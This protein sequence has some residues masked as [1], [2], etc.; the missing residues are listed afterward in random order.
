MGDSISFLAYSDIHHHEYKDGISGEDV[1][2][3]EEEA[4]QLIKEHQVDFW[5]FLGDR[6]VSRNPL[7]ISRQRADRA[8]KKKADLGIPGIL[9]PGNHD[10]RTKNPYSGHSMEH[11]DIYRSD[12]NNIVVFNEAHS[13]VV[14]SKNGTRVAVHGTPAGHIIPSAPLILAAEWNICIFHGMIIGSLFENGTPATEGIDP[15]VL[16]RS[17]YDLVLGG[18]NHKHQILPLR[19]TK[20]YYVGAPMQHNWGDVNSPRGFCL[21]TLTTTPTKQVQV[22]HILSHAPQFL[23]HQVRINEIEDLIQLVM[24]KRTEW[25]DNLIQL[26]LVGTSKSLDGI[27]PHEWETKI[28]EETKAR[29]VRIRLDFDIQLVAPTLQTGRRTEADEWQDYL[30]LHGPTLAKGLDLEK[31]KNLGLGYINDAPT[32]L[33]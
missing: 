29:V 2:A 6:F 14:L 28:K 30:A 11:V 22:Q 20:G 1:E 10:Q 13:Q 31:L 32:P 23:I 26:H 24:N 4:Y 12:L 16:D 15:A 7:D 25:K 9:L 18:D 8:L 3:V 27:I 17:D 19:N 5:M 21:V 33:L